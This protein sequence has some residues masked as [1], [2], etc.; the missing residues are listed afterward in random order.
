MKATL[1]L[2]A[3]TLLMAGCAAR[4]PGGVIP[5]DAGCPAQWAGATALCAASSSAC[6][7][8]GKRCTYPEA[9]D[10]PGSGPCADAVLG[11]DARPDGGARWTC[12][13]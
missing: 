1:I 7:E 10:C 13:Q 5:A 2:T 11:C 8:P 12:A 4:A 6:D 3:V 9:G